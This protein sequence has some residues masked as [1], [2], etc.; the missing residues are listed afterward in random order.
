METAYATPDY[1]VLF[2][3]DDIVPMFEVSN[4]THD[5]RRRRRLKNVPTDN[6]YA[7]SKRFFVGN[8]THTSFR[9]G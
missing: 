4:P 3:G 5:W 1:L 7:S 2:G 8:E 9:T 6:P